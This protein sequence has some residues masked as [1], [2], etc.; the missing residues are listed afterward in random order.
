MLNAD[1]WTD[2][3]TNIVPTYLYNYEYIFGKKYLTI[4]SAAEQKEVVLIEQKYE[5]HKSKNA[6]NSKKQESITYIVMRS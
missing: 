6:R 3:N 5:T 1:R 4:R 2:Q